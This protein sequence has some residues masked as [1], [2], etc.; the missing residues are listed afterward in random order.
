MRDTLVAVE[1]ET[2]NYADG[3]SWR[4]LDEHSAPAGGGV[5]DG[6]FRHGPRFVF[7]DAAIFRLEWVRGLGPEDLFE[8]RVADSWVSKWV[9]G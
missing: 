5:V 1:G 3:R 7:V 4:L 8:E 2:I 9:D 6:M